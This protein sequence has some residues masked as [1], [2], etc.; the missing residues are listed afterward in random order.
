MGLCTSL[1]PQSVCR[2]CALTHVRPLIFPC[3]GLYPLQG[4]KVVHVHAGTGSVLSSVT[5]PNNEFANVVAV[6]GD[7]QVSATRWWRGVWGGN[8]C[9]RGGATCHCV[10]AA[11]PLHNGT[12]GRQAQ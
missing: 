8:A 11:C 10:L 7:G 4:S 6:R 12:L 9:V 5:I 2:V 3:H 1:E